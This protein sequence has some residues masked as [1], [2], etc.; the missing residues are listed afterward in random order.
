M[1]SLFKSSI[2]K[3]KE[4]LVFQIKSSEALSLLRLMQSDI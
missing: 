2:F 3:K 1:F 4:T